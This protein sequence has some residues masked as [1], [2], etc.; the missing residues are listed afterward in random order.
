LCVGFHPSTTQIALR[1]LKLRAS[2]SKMS[3]PLPPT[4]GLPPVLLLTVENCDVPSSNGISVD[5]PCPLIKAHREFLVSLHSCASVKKVGKPTE[6]H[7]ISKRS[8]ALE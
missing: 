8:T 6:T 7:R 2:I 4:E 1:Q 3:N 5:A